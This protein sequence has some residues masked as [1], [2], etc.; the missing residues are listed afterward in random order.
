MPREYGGKTVFGA[1][2]GV[3]MLGTRFPGIKGDIANACTR[4]FPLQYRIVRGAS[5]H[6][7]ARQRAA[8]QLE[9]FIEA[10]GDPVF[11]GAD[12]LTTNCG[13]LSLIQDAVKDAVGVPVV[14]FR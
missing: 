11:H 8:G 4:P 2:V 13:F 6:R 14:T 9:G 3:M 12:G 7:V 10:T 5:P 1:S